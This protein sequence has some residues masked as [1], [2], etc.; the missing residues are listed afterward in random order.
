ME[1]LFKERKRRLDIFRQWRKKP[2]AKAKEIPDHVFMTC[3]HCHASVAVMDLVENQY[4]CPVCDHPFKISARERIRQLIDEHTFKETNAKMISIDPDHFPGYRSKLENL[5]KKTGMKEAVIT[6]VGKIMGHSCVIGVMDSNFFMGSMS[7]AVGE[8]I[9]CAIELATRKKLPLILCCTS[10]GARMQEGILSLVQMAKTSAAMKRHSD[11]GLLSITVLTHPTTGGV[12][13]SFAMLGDI[14]LS[15]PYALVGFAGKR[16]IED[17]IHEK[18]PD[19]FQTAEFVLE[20]GFI[21]RI[22][23][24]KDMKRELG[25]L[26]SFHCHRRTS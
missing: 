5:Q 21:D 14:I 1:N 15:E 3:A 7:A 18:L 11:A 20:K 16:V 26:L 25:W 13:A 23:P 12:S 4:V 19:N 10:G 6:G 24:R 8:K 9:T 2:K 22:V 17:T